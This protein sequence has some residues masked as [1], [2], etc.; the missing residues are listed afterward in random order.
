M[1]L[2]NCSN[3]VTISRI[4]EDTWLA[5]YVLFDPALLVDGADIEIDGHQ[6]EAQLLYNSPETGGQWWSA[7]YL[8]N[9]ALHLDAATDEDG[10]EVSGALDL[11]V[12]VSGG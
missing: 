6:A 7:A 3:W 10:G 5:P 1:G 12:L 2:A 9:G 4:A 8:G 11:F